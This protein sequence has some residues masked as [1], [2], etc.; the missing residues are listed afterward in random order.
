MPIHGDLASQWRGLQA[1][2]LVGMPEAAINLAQV[3]TYL[4]CA[5]KSN[6]SYMALQHQ[7]QERVEKSGTLHIP[8]ALRSAHPKAKPAIR[9]W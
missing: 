4:T 8:L 6:A 7:A 5:P 3:T 9:L 1:V 2:E